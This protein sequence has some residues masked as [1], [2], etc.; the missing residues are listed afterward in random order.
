MSRAV[1]HFVD[2]LDRLI[3]RFRQEYDMT[4]AEVIGCLHMKTSDLW[5]EAND[6]DDDEDE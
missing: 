6:E 5:L 3:D 1:D 4:Y 2:E